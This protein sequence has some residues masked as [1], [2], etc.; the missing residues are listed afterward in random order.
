M[1]L[2]HRTLA[3]HHRLVRIHPASQKVEKSLLHQPGKLTRSRRPRQGMV[4]RQKV[5]GLPFGLKLD[6]GPDHAE[7]VAQMQPT[8][9]LNPREITHP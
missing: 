3:E 5:V 8:G 4:V 7:V 6:G 1:H 2:R 9:R